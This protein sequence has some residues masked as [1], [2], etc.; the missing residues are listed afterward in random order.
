MRDHFHFYLNKYLITPFSSEHYKL[1]YSE[2]Y[3]FL[4]FRVAKCGSRTINKHLKELTGGEHIYSS[5]TG[6][7]RP[8]FKDYLKFAFVRNPIKR[9]ESAWRDKVVEQNYFGFSSSEHEKMQNI[10]R[11]IA[12]AEEMNIN[13]ADVHIRPQ[14]RLIDLNNID[15]LGRNE[16]FNKD[17]QTLFGLLGASLENVFH[18]NR[19][20]K[21]GGHQELSSEQKKK[22]AKIYELDFRLFYPQEFEEIQK[23]GSS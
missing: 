10:D 18:E 8:F 14:H 5:P 9:F 17:L 3:K 11:F 21:K 22:I 20:R 1:C 23:R 15:F 7:Y 16:S 6:Y 4:W 2:K 19:T 13:N 12:F